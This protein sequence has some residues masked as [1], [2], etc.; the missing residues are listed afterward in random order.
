MD[1][2][3]KSPIS[4]PVLLLG[5]G[6][7]LVC[8]FFFVV[9]IYAVDA[10]LVDSAIT[11]A[12]GGILYVVGLVVIVAAL[13]QL[14]SS[15]AVG[16]PERQTELRTRGLYRFSRN[17][18]YVGG[19]IL[20]AGSCFFSMHPINLACFVLTVAVHARIIA[21]EEEFLEKR[22]G[23]QWLEYKRRVPRYLGKLR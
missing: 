2:I 10:M 14:G 17:P 22:F 23:E 4:L 12:V 16:I 1:L 8:A 13:I 20:C 15:T 11:R 3:G 7:L 6:A 21:K 5:K 18:I 19:F 9:R